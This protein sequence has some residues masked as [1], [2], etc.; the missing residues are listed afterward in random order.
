MNVPRVS[1]FQIELATYVTLTNMDELLAAARVAEI[2]LP[3]HKTRPFMQI[4]SFNGELRKAVSSH[5]L[6]TS[7]LRRVT[8]VDRQIPQSWDNLA[9]QFYGQQG[10]NSF[11]TTNFKQPQT[12]QVRQGSLTMD[13][14]G[15]T[16]SS[17]IIIK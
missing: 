12:N 2:T 17:T 15:M 1:Q 11:T 10:P 14:S 3:R 7:S 13:S 9:R 8:S 16:I 4:R 6:P 5:S